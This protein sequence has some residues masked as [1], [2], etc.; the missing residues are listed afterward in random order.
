M[1][2]GKC[3]AVIES[4]KAQSIAV[5][6]HLLCLR[7]A[8]K[9]LPVS[10]RGADRFMISAVYSYFLLLKARRSGEKLTKSD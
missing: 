1:I 9:F 10:L 3:A 7:L 5:H 4:P 8:E 2:S 6:S